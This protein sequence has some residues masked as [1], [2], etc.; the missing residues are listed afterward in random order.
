M[1]SVGPLPRKDRAE[2]R[3]QRPFRAAAPLPVGASGEG[4]KAGKAAGN[5][6]TSTA[7]E[8]RMTFRLLAPARQ[9]HTWEFAANA[10]VRWGSCCSLLRSIIALQAQIPEHSS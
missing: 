7:K 10:P 4:E 6:Y 9:Q 8:S 5:M 1:P 3:G 2:V